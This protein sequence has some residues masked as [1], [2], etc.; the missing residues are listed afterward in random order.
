MPFQFV[1]SFKSEVNSTNSPLPANGVFTGTFENVKDFATISITVFSD[2]NGAS[3]VA[4]DFQWSTDGEHVDFAEGTGLVGGT[5][6]G[7]AITARAEHFRIVYTNGSIAQSEFRL[8]VVYHASGTGLI[9]RPLGKGLT[10]DNFAQTVR[11]VL[12]AQRDDGTYV[13]LKATSDGRLRIKI[14]GSD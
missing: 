11:A 12:C 2:K 7:F 5:G 3:P 8:G 13:N 1:E 6:R 4:L 9:S 14:A 10:D